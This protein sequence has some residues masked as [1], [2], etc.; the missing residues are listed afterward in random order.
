[1]LKDACPR[2]GSGMCQRGRAEESVRRVYLLTLSL[3]PSD[4]ADNLNN[5]KQV[6]EG[7]DW[8]TEQMGTS[9]LVETGPWAPEEIQFLSSARDGAIAAAAGASF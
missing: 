3:P 8:F 1:M 7:N 2:G 4:L 6:P 9:P 5:F